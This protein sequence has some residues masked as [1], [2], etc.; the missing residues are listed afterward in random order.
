MFK[1]SAPKRITGAA[2]AVVV[3][4][5][6]TGCFANPL[7]GIVERASEE[8]AKNI[9]E[10]LIET[11]TGGE[12]GIEIGDLP[13]DFPAEVTLVSENIVQSATV[14]GSTV[15]LV[16]DTRG[17]RELQ[18]QVKSDYAGWEETSSYQT[19]VMSIRRYENDEWVVAVSIM[20]MEGEEDR[21]V[22]YSVTAQTE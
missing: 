8:G 7:D 12:A 4:A 19:E 5:M 2:L 11:A 18:D 22:S 6:L 1:R 16:S 17:Y 3:A 20:A 9:A 21:M 13:D 10:E 14:E 15:V